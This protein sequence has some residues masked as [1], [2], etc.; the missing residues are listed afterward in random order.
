MR[1]FSPLVSLAMLAGCNDAKTPGPVYDASLTPPPSLSASPS[2]AP[3]LVIEPITQ[4][5]AEAHDLMG[6]GCTFST[7][8]SKDNDWLVQTSDGDAHFRTGGALVHLTAPVKSGEAYELA[9][10]R[11]DSDRFSLHITRGPGKERVLGE[12]YTEQDGSVSIRDKAGAELYR[13]KGT[14]GCGA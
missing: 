11:Y 8:A 3:R 7:V 4:A 10:A 2:P 13:A 9:R 12:E 5:Y 1:M 14:F 6:V